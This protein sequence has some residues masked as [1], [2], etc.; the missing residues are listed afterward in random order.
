MFNLRSSCRTLLLQSNT[1]PLAVLLV[2]IAACTGD[3]IVDP[4]ASSPRPVATHQTV[5]V[6]PNYSAF[7]TRPE[8]NLVGGIDQLNSFEEFTGDVVYMQDTPWTTHGVTYTSDLNIV[9]GP[10]AGL[11]IQSNSVATEFGA[12]LTVTLGGDDAFTMVGADLTTVGTKTPVGFVATTNLGTY[13]IDN[14]DVP[15]ATTG[16]RFLGIALSTPGEHL[17]GLR[18]TVGGPGTAILLDNVA[19]GHVALKAANSSPEVSAGGAYTGTEG[20]PISFAFSAADADDDLLTF[21]WDLGDGTVGTGAAPPTSHTYADDGAYPVMLAVD[22]GHG[23]VDTART[24]A[25]ISNVAPTLAAFSVPSVPLA[26]AN[27]TASIAVS[28]AFSDPGTADTQTAELD[29]GTGSAVTAPAPNGKAG[30]ICT[31]SSPGVYTVQLTVADDDG[32]SDTKVGS[33]QIVVYS[34]VAGWLTGGGWIPSPA[35]ANLAAPSTS[36]KLTFGFVARYTPGSTA[37][38]GNA[39]FKLNVGKLDFRSTALDWLVV[40]NN[41]AQLQGRGTLSGGGDYGFAV[42]A[43]DGTV[44]GGIRIRIWLRAT[45]GVVY[46]SNP[47]DPFEA[48]WLTP[49]GGGSI[50]LHRN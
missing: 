4:R 33:G 50:Q 44:A 35:G 38:E 16:R 1:A 12:P 18:F 27:G 10:G 41:T 9:L 15:L 22:D 45:G 42:I 43:Q 8:F 14:L 13:S 26:L 28:S 48:E 19:V 29:C 5:V 47:G 6:T 25:T 39:E 34:A 46:D 21:S 30:G 31:Y 49:L 36:G 23:G 40:A 2:A 20:S 11:G 3:G 32:G 7:D 17:T 24:T 37:P